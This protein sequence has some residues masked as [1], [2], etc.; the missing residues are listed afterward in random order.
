MHSIRQPGSDFSPSAVSIWFLNVFYPAFISGA[1]YFLSQMQIFPASRI[2][3]NT[4]PRSREN[5]GKADEGNEMKMARI[6]LW[7]F[8][9]LEIPRSLTF[10]Q[11]LMHGI[12]WQSNR[13][14][15]EKILHRIWKNDDWYARLVRMRKNRLEIRR[16]LKSGR[17]ERGQKIQV[18]YYSCTSPLKILPRKEIVK[19]KS[20]HAKSALIWKP[21]KDLLAAAILDFW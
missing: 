21:W 14:N 16:R 5:Q 17:T 8:E 3:R 10:C 13:L 7:A 9:I 4:P 20:P 19:A 15:L 18:Y 1:P 11:K 2:H 12:L 6:Q